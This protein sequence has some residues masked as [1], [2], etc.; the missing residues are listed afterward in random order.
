MS[1]LLFYELMLSSWL[2]G[3]FGGASANVW[4]IAA[5]VAGSILFVVPVVLRRTP[6]APEQI[7]RFNL[8]TCL[9]L[10]VCLG[11]LFWFRDP[12]DFAL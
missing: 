3:N 7:A 6:T 9:W 10:L 2:L 1:T 8:W 11:A 5:A 4:S 12:L